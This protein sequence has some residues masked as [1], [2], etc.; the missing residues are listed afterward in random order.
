MND[1]VHALAVSDHGIYAGG[2]FT[3]AGGAPA[4]RVARWDGTRW[5]PL[6]SGVRAGNNGV[7][8][9][10]LDGPVLFVGGGFY[11]AGGKPSYQ[12]ARFGNSPPRVEIVSP[13]NHSV[14]AAPATLNVSVAAADNDGSIQRVELYLGASLVAS[15]TNRPYE[16]TL[17]NAPVGSYVLQAVA[18]DNY[19]AATTSAPVDVEVV[20]INHAPSF[21]I[22]PDLELLEDSG[23]QSFPA[24]A[25]G[26]MAGPA[27]ESGQQL[28][29]IVTN[30]NSE[31]FA[32]QPVI[33]PDGRLTFAPAED[34]FGR[35]VVSVVLQ[36]NGGTAFGGE[37][38]SPMQTF[39]ILIAPVNDQPSFKAG[40]DQIILEDAG[41]Q[42]VEG[43]ATN[44]KPG[45]AN[46]SSQSLQ[47]LVS[48][49]HAAL[50]AVP[51]AVD[52]I[53][54]LRYTPSAG[55]CGTATVSVVLRDNGGTSDGGYD[56]SES[57]IFQ[58]EVQC[59][60]CP[61]AAALS[62]T[63]SYE[64]PVH[65]QLPAM[66]ADG[67]PLEY[68]V[69]QQPRYGVLSVQRQTGS[70]SY[71][72]HNRYCGPDSFN[73][74]VRDGTCTSA[75]ATVTINVECGLRAKKQQLLSEL[76]ALRAVS[77][78]RSDRKHLD[79]IIEHIEDSLVES[80]WMDHNHLVVKKG[81]KAFE[82]DEDAADELRE[83]L[84]DA[85]DRESDIPA[86]VLQDYLDRLVAIARALAVLVIDEAE[87]S[88]GK[89][90]KI[91]EVRKEIGQGDKDAAKGRADKAIKHYRDA[92]S[93]AVKL[94]VTSRVRMEG[95]AG[96]RLHFTGVAGEQYRL[97]VS[98]DF[99]HWT[100]LA[101]LTADGNGDM[102]YTD[103]DA[104]KHRSRF[105]RLVQ[106]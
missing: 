57:Q 92:W 97:E 28:T 11:Y 103:V 93:H 18:F 74:Q 88:G 55:A 21:A 96:F 91:W 60:S 102:D 90:E 58:I 99:T 95:K 24:W 15:L 5:F 23:A 77:N 39:S 36:D 38:S 104:S 52:S 17:S 50:F 73:F 32:N 79:D 27:S 105:Y 13:T 83:L 69:T 49:N 63:T 71:T 54:T 34:A 40:P 47:F 84:E 85:E 1:I 35:A 94:K 22:G 2:R 29:F 76:N 80:L 42:V 37:D 31:L 3:M 89:P 8:A 48:N 67:D 30:D 41:P 64:T 82:E 9:L 62:V 56:A 25:T 43:W 16:F 10:G 14:V 61:V 26:I 87:A 100:L 4:N 68:I 70:A 53:G 20:F 98:S 86:A 44:I 7:Y 106:P 12:F 72:P 19:G 81:R 75:A 46:E 45:P 78:D 66:D 65:F 51:P 101:T 33:A 6:G 59:V